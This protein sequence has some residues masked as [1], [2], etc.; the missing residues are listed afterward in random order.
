MAASP[1]LT[2]NPDDAANA[3]STPATALPSSSK[4]GTLAVP[5]NR[6]ETPSPKFQRGQNKPKCKQCG[7][8]ARSRCPYESCKSCCFRNQ[9]PCHI[10]DFIELWLG[11]GLE[12]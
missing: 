6:A 1:A 10:H 7:N 2:T 3:T 9:N 11:R 12:C 8:V 5:A 4:T